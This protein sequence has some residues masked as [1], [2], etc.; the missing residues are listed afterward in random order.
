MPTPAQPPVGAAA[1]VG[2]VGAGVGGDAAGTAT[3]RN[4]K[5]GEPRY[6]NVRG[7]RLA[8]GPAGEDSRHVAARYERDRAANLFNERGAGPVTLNTAKPPLP[9]FAASA[10]GS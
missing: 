9:A 5:V 6:T 10:N 2:E 7:P 1:G 4:A 8:R 3:P